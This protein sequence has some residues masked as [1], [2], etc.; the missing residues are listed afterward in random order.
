MRALITPD[1]IRLQIEV[2]NW[3]QGVRESAELL[4]QDG[5]ITREYI[6]AIFTSF[7]ANGDYMIVM[8]EIVLAHARPEFGAIETGISLVTLRHPV[9]YQDDPT[10]PICV[11]FTLAAGNPDEHIEMMKAL[12]MVLIDDESTHRLKT[13]EDVDA[14]LRVLV[15]TET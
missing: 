1:R 8:P 6:D 7:E 9:L 14:V 4:L 13:S 15:S 12:A 10:R 11:I 5:C 2:D 3:S